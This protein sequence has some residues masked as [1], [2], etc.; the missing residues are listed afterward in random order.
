V[1]PHIKDFSGNTDDQQME[2]VQYERKVTSLSMSLENF[3]DCDGVSALVVLSKIKKDVKSVP[4]GLKPN[5]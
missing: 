4:F 5:L 2:S 1:I 3:T